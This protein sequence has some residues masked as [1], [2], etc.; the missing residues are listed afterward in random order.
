M[1]QIGLGTFAIR[2][3]AARKSIKEAILEVGYRHLDTAELYKNEAEIGE[4]LQE[5]F[6]AGLKREEIFITTKLWVDDVADPE[7]ALKTSLGKLKLDYV[8]LY[9]IHWPVTPFDK[10]TGKHAKIPFYKTWQ[11]MEGLV[12]AGLTKAIGISNF[13]VQF[14]LDILTYAEIKPAVNQLELHPYLAQVDA[15][16][17]YK[18]MG[19]VP[20]AY[21]P[22]LS[23]NTVGVFPRA[24]T[25]VLLDDPLVKE[26]AEKYG[27]SKGQ[28]ILNWG[29]ARGHVIIPKS[30]NKARQ[31]ENMESY[32]FKM[33]KE[34]V[35]KL[36]GLS[37]GERWCDISGNPNLGLFPVFH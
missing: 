28:I 33:E 1:P 19:I 25:K 32:Q 23:P 22:L 10:D 11:K 34:D 5:C 12:K 24:D 3:E 6:E 30:S 21:S 36:T 18:K 7:A 9:L 4:V 13:N 26:L 14:T 29:L 17:W 27:K 37:C 35:E 31:I 16:E 8:D 15:V 20:E 2:D